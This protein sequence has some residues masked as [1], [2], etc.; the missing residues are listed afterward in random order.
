MRFTIADID[1][2]KGNNNCT[3]N[4]ECINKPGS[5]SCLCIKG[6]RQLDKPVGICVPDYPL[7]THYLAVGKYI[8][9]I[10]LLHFAFFFVFKQTEY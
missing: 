4:Q 7:L 5:Y 3:S 9:C 8:Y 6:Y 10:S 2:C 1:E